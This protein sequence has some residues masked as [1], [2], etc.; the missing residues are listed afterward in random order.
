M[1]GVEYS[2]PTKQYMC[3]TCEK[4]HS[5]IPEYGLNIC[6]ATSQLH[7]FHNPRD[8][9]VTCAPDELHVDWLTIPGARIQT[10]ETAWQID[11]QNYK[12]PMR[13]LL[14]AGLNDLIKGGNKESVTNSI[15]R[16]KNAIDDQNIHHPDNP[17]ELVVAIL[18]NPPK[19][20]WFD[21]NGP[22]PPG[23]QNRLNEIEDINT[24][25]VEFNQGYGLITPRFHRFG[26]RTGRKMMNGE[27]VKMH[28]HQFRKWRQSEPVEDMLH[29]N[30]YWRT[31][32]GA[33]VVNHFKS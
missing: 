24:W 27:Y 7:D 5:V 6:L 32:L 4:F 29:L 28:A 19:L 8:P 20:T 3:P 15:L 2:R 26:V 18:P 1:Q 17:N 13:I 14:A 9:D 30:D 23:H 25:I 16:L 33:A 31:R 22:P 10:L 12:H 11:Y 21:D